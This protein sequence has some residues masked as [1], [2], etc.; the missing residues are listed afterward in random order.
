MKRFGIFI[1]ACAAALAEAFNLA[2]GRTHLSVGAFLGTANPLQTM[3][4]A[5]FSM[6]LVCFL[7]GL[8]TGDNS[9]VDRLWSILP[10]LY[11][12]FYCVRSWPDMRSAILCI[13]VSL[14]GIRLT[15][16]F[17]RKG[18]YTG[19]EDYRWAVLRGKIRNPII[20]QLF[21]LGF[22]SLFQML[23]IALFTSPLHFLYLNRGKAP[24]ISYVIICFAFIGFWLIEAEADREQALFQTMKRE[25]M[26]GKAIPAR[27]DAEVRQG[28]I[29]SGLFACSR[30]ANYFG[31]LGQWLCVALAGYLTSGAIFSFAG[32]VILLALFAGST[33]FTESISK[34][35]YP[36]YSEY[37]KRTSPII[38]WVPESRKTDS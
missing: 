20:W 24:D 1:I 32:F 2:A 16:N 30:H 19:E 5:A 11:G 18:G 25:H 37:Q 15:C 33:T 36:M 23:V 26:A 8:V 27:W 3:F 21:N 4:L 29:S 10:P 34:S 6:A 9:W 12:I 28:F 35:K 22:I 38:P 31:E 17:A 14:W 13:L 7:F